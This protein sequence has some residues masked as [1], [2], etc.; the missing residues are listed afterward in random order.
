MVR[1]NYEALELTIITIQDDVICTSGF[2]NSEAP[3]YTN[4]TRS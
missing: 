2:G 1:K 3:T 4:Q